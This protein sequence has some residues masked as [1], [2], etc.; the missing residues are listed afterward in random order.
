MKKITPKAICSWVPKREED[1]YKGDYGRVLIIAGSKRY[2]G[3]AIMAAEACVK[4]GA[5]LVTVAT[6][7]VNRSALHA[8][9]PECMFLDNQ[10]LKTLQTLLPTFDVVLIGSGL[11]RDEL[12]RNLLMLTLQTLASEQTVILDGDALYLY[13]QA[14][15][16]TKAT[17]IF[18]PHL[19]EWEYLKKLTFEE[20]NHAKAA[21]LGGI[22]VL[23]S[24]RTTVYTEEEIWQNIYGTP[25]MATGG[26]GD[27]LAGMIAG[28]TAQTKHVL[29]GVLIAV[30]LHS[31]IGELL[32]NKKYVVLPTEISANIPIY[33]KTFSEMDEQL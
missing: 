9:L 7:I 5:G 17:L 29:Q 31:Y 18:T 25:A 14:P 27:T 15:V 13:S 6:D 22:V 32:A 21:E 16:Q 2:G 11:D 19:G 10:D 8:R 30:F 1:S 33:L 24:H 4:S 28:L 26:M 12:A 20:T 23:K 3:A